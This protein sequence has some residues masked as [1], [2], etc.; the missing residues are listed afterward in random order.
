MEESIILATARACNATLWTQ[1][2]HFKLIEGM[3]QREEGEE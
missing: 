3:V 1:D 2:K